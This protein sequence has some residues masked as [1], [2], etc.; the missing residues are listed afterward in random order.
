MH[1][2]GRTWRGSRFVDVITGFSCKPSAVAFRPIR[3]KG[4]R[5]G[6]TKEVVTIDGRFSSVSRARFSQ[7]PSTQRNATHATPLRPLR[8]SIA[9]KP[10]GG[11]YSAP[12]DPLAAGERAHPRAV[13][14]F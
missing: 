12:P 2:D 11:A 8:I 1:G 10:A 3:V 4:Q 14:G 7:C 9:L 5:V 13:V 6:L